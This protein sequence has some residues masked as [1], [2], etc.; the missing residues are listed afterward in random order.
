M[1]TEAERKAGDW[2]VRDFYRTRANRSMHGVESIETVGCDWAQWSD[3]STDRLL[4]P[5]VCYRCLNHHRPRYRQSMSIA[6]VPSV[7]TASRAVWP[8]SV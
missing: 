4:G 6:S 8:R 1:T 5:A 7:S 2:N 3:R